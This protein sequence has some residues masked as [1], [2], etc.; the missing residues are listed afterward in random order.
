MKEVQAF[1]EMT[2]YKLRQ[3]IRKM[4]QEHPVVHGSAKKK[5]KGEGILK[6]Y[7]SN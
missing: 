5:K 1:R 2:D 3:E 4:G 7:K 6:G